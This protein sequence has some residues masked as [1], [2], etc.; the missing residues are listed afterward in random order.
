LMTGITTAASAI[1]LIMAFGPGAE[2]RSVIGV[3]VLGGVL[4][5]TFLTLYLVPAAYSLI[6]R[7]TGSPGDIAKRLAAESNT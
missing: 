1:P 5:A 6:S 3:V 7:N 2:T 4:L